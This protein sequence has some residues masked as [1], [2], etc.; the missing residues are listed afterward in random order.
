MSV[1]WTVIC[2]KCKLYCHLGQDMGGTSSFGYGSKDI[3]GQNIV[4][5]FI[6]THINYEEPLKIVMTDKI[7]KDYTEAKY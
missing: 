5:E 3:K 6:A 4:L 7:P 1:D 2:D